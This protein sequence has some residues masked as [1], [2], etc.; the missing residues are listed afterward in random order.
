M[1]TAVVA[2]LIVAGKMTASYAAVAMIAATAIDQTIQKRNEAKT[3]SAPTDAGKID[4][5]QLTKAGEV[6]DL[7][8]GEEA[9][10]KANR[11]KGKAQ[12]KVKLDTDGTGDNTQTTKT[13][14]QI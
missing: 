6:S 4:K 8:I 10:K 9:K 5:T 13:G 12:F 11:K 14:V 7:Q 1:A 2:G 3:D